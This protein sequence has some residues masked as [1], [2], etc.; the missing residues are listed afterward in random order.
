MRTASGVEAISAQERE[1]EV[2]EQGQPLGRVFIAGE[3]DVAEA[4]P[5]ISLGVDVVVLYAAR[6][7]D[8][9]ALGLDERRQR[10]R[11][12]QATTGELL[13]G[14]E[15]TMNQG[16]GVVLQQDGRQP[17]AIDRTIAERAEFSAQRFEEPAILA[18]E[19]V[20]AVEAVRLEHRIR[21]EVAPP[22]D[23]DVGETGEGRDRGLT[24]LVPTYG[25]EAVRHALRT[26]HQ[27]VQP[28]RS[29]ETWRHP[30]PESRSAETAAPVRGA[31]AR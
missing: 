11:H 28:A 3:R 27:Q 13:L 19:E 6:R 25:L 5:G 12:P 17:A 30:D 24:R 15:D 4:F 23:A 26:L 7:R 21:E 29:S 16:G 1:V 14:E 22:C 10:P 9:H 2:D 8:A 20:R 18:R 31:A